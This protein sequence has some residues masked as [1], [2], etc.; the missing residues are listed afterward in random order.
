MAFGA[1]EVI[2]KHQK[3]VPIFSMDGLKPAQEAIQRGEMVYS[4]RADF[5]NEIDTALQ[6]AVNL[7]TGQPTHQNLKYLINN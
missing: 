3:K 4:A 7:V 1:L 2:A 5:N 6:L